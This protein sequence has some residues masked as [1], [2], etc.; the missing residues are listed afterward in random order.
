MLEVRESLD[1]PLPSDHTR[2]DAEPP[3]PKGFPQ[4]QHGPCHGKGGRP[5]LPLERWDH[6][7]WTRPVFST[8]MEK[9]SLTIL[10]LLVL[11]TGTHLKGNAALCYIF[12]S[13][14]L[15]HGCVCRT[16]YSH[17]SLGL[18]ISLSQMTWNKES[19]AG[20]CKKLSTFSSW[21]ASET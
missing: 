13:C 3:L 2:P 15:T 7:A 1:I 9:K 21:W 5:C 20:S 18:W 4:L 10:I 6:Q 11:G 12:F 8:S 19:K 17:H 14:S 16:S